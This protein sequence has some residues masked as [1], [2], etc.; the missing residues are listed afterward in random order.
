MQ[1]QNFFS[2]LRGKLPQLHI[3]L[4]RTKLLLFAVTLIAFGL[5]LG[6]LESGENDKEVANKVVN[7]GLP[8]RLDFQLPSAD[9]PANFS[10]D[11]TAVEA[12]LQAETWD[13]VT[14]RSGQSL[15]G[16][17][18]QQGFSAKTLHEIMSLSEETKQLKKIRP[19]DL[20]EFQRHEDQ[21]LKRMRYAIDES[22]YLIIDH[23]GEQAYAS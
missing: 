19:G 15:D 22:H 7:L 23:D 10:A 18:R 12:G 13:N 16:I 1:N 5:A 3:R 9:E 6:G 17:F 20:F 14:V 2:E 8:E 11:G 21:S 4:T